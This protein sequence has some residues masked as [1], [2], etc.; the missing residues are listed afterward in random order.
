MILTVPT[1]ALNTRKVKKNFIYNRTTHP[2]FFNL[3]S[4]GMFCVLL[5]STFC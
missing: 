1:Q 3:L 2:L 4:S 5:K